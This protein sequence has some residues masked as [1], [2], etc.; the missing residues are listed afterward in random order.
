MENDW[1]NEP[2]SRESGAFE[3]RD[4]FSLSKK[5]KPYYSLWRKFTTESE[6]TK[7]I[8]LYPNCETTLRDPPMKNELDY[9]QVGQDY[10]RL[11]SNQ[12]QDNIR[13]F[14]CDS[15]NRHPIQVISLES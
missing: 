12:Y 3:C 11:K 9:N 8:A 10:S 13:Q 5:P 4:F 2:E 7:G 6:Y 15:L 1:E 14:Q